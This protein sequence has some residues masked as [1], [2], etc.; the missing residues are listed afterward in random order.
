VSKAAQFQP[1][2][3]PPR[4]NDRD[5]KPH[6]LQERR[7]SS[8]RPC[9]FCYGTGVDPHRDIE[10]PSCEGSGWVAESPDSD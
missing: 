6:R 8:G 4:P 2:R 5:P 1:H 9:P 7:E 3:R 10:C